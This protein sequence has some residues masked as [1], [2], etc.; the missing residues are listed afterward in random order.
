[1]LAEV[2]AR[3]NSQVVRRFKL[4][5]QPRPQAQPSRIGIPQ[6]APCA[7]QPKPTACRSYRW[8]RANQ[9]HE[10]MHART[11]GILNTGIL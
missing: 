4:T 10:R 6:P 3:D 9:P 11:Q 2:L 5:F 1:M 7:C 8:G